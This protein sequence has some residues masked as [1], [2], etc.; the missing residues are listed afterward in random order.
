[1]VGILIS[2]WNSPSV[3]V[4]WYYDSFWEGT[5]LGRPFWVKIAPKSKISFLMKSWLNRLRLRDSRFMGKLHDLRNHKGWHT[6]DG[7]NPANQLISSLSPY[8]QGFIHPRWETAGFLPSTVCMCISLLRWTG[9]NQNDLKT[10]WRRVGHCRSVL[11]ITQL[12]LTSKY[13]N[14]GTTLLS[15]REK[16]WLCNPI[17]S[18]TSTNKEEFFKIQTREP[19][20]LGYEQCHFGTLIKMIKCKLCTVS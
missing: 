15:L 6:V 16:I 10:W 1:M 14:I 13:S 12:D 17:I 11:I 3:Q 2:F 7:R 20:S 19:L 5:F 8:L 4:L 9:S 18:F